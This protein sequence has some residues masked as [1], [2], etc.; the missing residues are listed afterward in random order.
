ME[1]IGSV[2][3]RTRSELSGSSGCVESDIEAE[4]S[5]I[6]AESVGVPV[7]AGAVCCLW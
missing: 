7:D 5:L 3:F 1:R 2:I 6:A 4:G